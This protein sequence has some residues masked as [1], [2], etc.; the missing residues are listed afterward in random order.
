MIFTTMNFTDFVCGV[1]AG[2][3][4]VLVGQPFDFAK[5]RIQ[6][7]LNAKVNIPAIAKDIYR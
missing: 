3:A 1:T 6:S 2:W 5:V 4:Q 7:A